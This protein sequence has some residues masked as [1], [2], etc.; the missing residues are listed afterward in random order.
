VSIENITPEH[1]A[2]DADRQA[3]LQMIEPLVDAIRDRAVGEQRRE[4]AP[5]CVDEGRVA[6]DI[7]EGLLLAGKAGVWQVFGGRAAADRDID[8]FVHPLAEPIVGRQNRFFDRRGQCAE[9]EG[10]TDL[11]PA[12]LEIADIARI[13]PGDER[14]NL[15]IEM[16]ALEKRAIGAHGDREA[17]RHVD[18]GCAQCAPQLAERGILPADQ[19]D[20]VNAE[21]VEPSNE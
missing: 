13:E 16:V 18:S 19:G 11:A 9:Q 3:D 7:E 12:L 10:L 2:L 6:L 5:A 8:G 4:G 14:A 20:V 21:V 15:F 1:H 17:V